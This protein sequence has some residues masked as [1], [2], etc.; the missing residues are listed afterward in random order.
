MNSITPTSASS[1]ARRTVEMPPVA[2]RRHAA[3]I[4][5]ATSHSAAADSPVRRVAILL[6]TFN[7]EN[8]LVEQLESLARQTWPDINVVVSDDQSTDHTQRQLAR[9]AN[10]WS[11]GSFEITAGP[12]RGF[13]AN[14]RSLILSHDAET[15]N[16][17]AFCDQDDIWDPGKL[18]TAIGWLETLPE[19]MPGLHCGRTRNFPASSSGELSPLFTRPPCF[20]NAIVQSIAGANT[21][22]M[23]RHAFRLVQEAARRTDFVSHDWWSYMIVTGAGGMVRY[24]PEPDILYR[25]HEGNLVGANNTWAAR[26]TRLQFIFSGRFRQWSDLNIA[27][28]DKCRDLL[29]GEACRVLDDFKAARSGGPLA[30]LKALRRSGVFRQTRK[31]QAGLVLACMLGLI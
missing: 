4:D 9:Y 28:L 24:N 29:T 10:S 22:V 8:Y 14:F 26:F 6:A 13:A 20:R 25:Q 5:A 12:C 30:R 23:N 17:V 2:A 19:G 11:K 3:D 1:R 18:E 27:G 15:A 31:G 7:G 16:Y 21:M